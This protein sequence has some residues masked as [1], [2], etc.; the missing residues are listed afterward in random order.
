MEI[1][2]SR[3]HP[4]GKP[5]TRSPLS[6]VKQ[7]ASSDDGECMGFSSAEEAAESV[8]HLGQ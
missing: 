3:R 2:K 7:E 4:L 5:P 8:A 6:V 1:K